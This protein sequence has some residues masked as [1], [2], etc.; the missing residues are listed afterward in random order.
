M[1]IYLSDNVGVADF[2]EEK[3]KKAKKEKSDLPIK[4]YYQPENKFN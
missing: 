3:D 2:E 4:I 1:F